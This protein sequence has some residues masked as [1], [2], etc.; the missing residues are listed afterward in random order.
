MRGFGRGPPAKE[1]AYEALGI[2]RPSSRREEGVGSA[3]ASTGI[4]DRKQLTGIVGQL[5]VVAKK[6]SSTDNQALLSAYIATL[7]P[8]IFSFG[9]VQFPNRL[10]SWNNEISHACSVF[11]LLS[12]KHLTF[13]DFASISRFITRASLEKQLSLSNETSIGVYNLLI[14]YLK[15]R[16]IGC[17]TEDSPIEST[18]CAPGLLVNESMRAVTQL[19]LTCG[20]KLQAYRHDAL[21]TL[22]IYCDHNSVDLESRYAAIDAVGNILSHRVTNAALETISGNKNESKSHK[23]NELWMLHERCALMLVDNLRSAIISFNS[24]SGLKNSGG[25]SL[26]CKLLVSCL[27]AL[28]Q[29]LSASTPPSSTT[30]FNSPSSSALSSSLIL[31]Q[32]LTLQQLQQ[33][34]FQQRYQSLVQ[35]VYSIFSNILTP[36][37]SDSTTTA[38][39]P[40]RKEKVFKFDNNDVLT[41]TKLWTHVCRLLSALALYSPPVFMS[42]WQL[43]LAD[44]VTMENALQTLTNAIHASITKSTLPAAPPVIKLPVFKSPIFSSA[45]RG[46]HATK[47]VAIQC[48]A[49]IL[50]ELPMQKWF[51]SKGG[52]N[53]RTGT[54]TSLKDNTLKVGKAVSKKNMH[55]GNSMVDNITNTII[56]IYR[57]VIVMLTVE[58]DDSVVRELLGVCLVLV[59]QLPLD[60]GIPV[61]EDLSQVMFHIV[62]RIAVTDKHNHGAVTLCVA[63]DESKGINSSVHALDFLDRV[64]LNSANPPKSCYDIMQL[65][66]YRTKGQDSSVSKVDSAESTLGSNSSWRKGVRAVEAE[67]NTES[68][69]Q[70]MHLFNCIPDLEADVFIRQ[71]AIMSITLCESSANSHQSVACSKV[72][73]SVCIK[74]PQLLIANKAW[75]RLF[76]DYLSISPILPMRHVAAKCIAAL[77]STSSFHD[78]FLS[79]YSLAEVAVLLLH[80]CGDSDHQ[81]RCEAIGA[82]GHFSKPFW[83]QLDEQESIIASGEPQKQQRVAI[84]DNLLKLTKD[85]IGTV[86]AAAYK[87]LGEFICHGGLITKRSADSSPN[88][89]PAKGTSNGSICTI[90]SLM[91]T[92]IL[93]TFYVG[94]DDSKL[95]VRLQAIWALGNL[96]LFILPMRQ[97]LSVPVKMAPLVPEIDNTDV[98]VI[99]DDV[100]T[101]ADKV[102]D[103]IADHAWMSNYDVCLRLLDDSEKLLASSVRC[104][105]FITAGLSPWNSSHFTQ[106]TSIVDTLI[107]K[108]LLSTGDDMGEDITFRIQKSIN[109][110]PHKLL[111]SI[112]QALGFIGWVL[113]NKIETNHPGS[114]TTP[115][116]GDDNSLQAV[117]FNIEKVRG[118]LAI[119]LRHSKTKI[120]LQACKA[121]ISLICFDSIHLDST[122][123]SVRTAFT[124]SIISAMEN[125]FVLVST[126]LSKYSAFGSSAST[127]PISP[128]SIKY[129]SGL[130]HG[131]TGRGQTNGNIINNNNINKSI[132]TSNSA[133]SFIMQRSLLVLVWVILQRACDCC[134]NLKH[135]DE[136]TDTSDDDFD[137]SFNK[138]SSISQSIIYHSDDLIKWMHY[139]SA[140]ATI[141][142]SQELSLTSPPLASTSP[143]LNFPTASTTKSVSSDVLTCCINILK[144]HLLVSKAVIASSDNS[145]DNWLTI[146]DSVLDKLVNSYSLFSHGGNVSTPKKSISTDTTPFNSITDDE[147]DE[148]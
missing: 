67:N 148:I 80:L 47:I 77:L 115:L 33:P 111:Y 16:G 140:E 101:I 133:R 78:S 74:Y 107:D 52:F 142:T 97:K 17:R 104:L 89:S 26:Q 116:L 2:A 32:Y 48:L 8:L 141:L 25:G 136:G 118:V 29:A 41:D 147:D 72:L 71:L 81:I 75:F 23:A 49:S 62:L 56:K 102:D 7:S 10:P 123:M 40:T 109:D 66:A 130:F 4:T 37:P 106:L 146:Y 99:T 132:E 18:K 22:L 105:G 121:L 5:E 38:T 27:R 138:L 21:T 60:C 30:T 46:H 55:A 34:I 68:D 87:A 108:I 84:V 19:L 90:E 50:M 95:A 63:S 126:Y 15:C 145:N 92:T 86:R 127:L 64:L 45:S 137:D 131:G 31:S 139:M 69:S 110:L 65:N 13:Q 129:R 85:K 3:S 143:K 120:Q 98:T 79:I 36:I 11:S 82:F 94:C 12:M 28:S 134:M 57:F 88:V 58:K 128:E 103:C 20:D 76:F 24:S 112:C 42:S 91:I 114:A 135:N 39:T 73:H 53:A 1:G 113:A 119:I 83:L 61:L 43:F 117:Y 54:T 144:Q 70:R 125:A 35:T 6:L 93:Q 14:S 122:R 51:L 59:K 9:N 44:S 100:G 124:S 96:L